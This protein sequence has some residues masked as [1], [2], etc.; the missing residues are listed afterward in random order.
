MRTIYS[1]FTILILASLVFVP[2]Y[3]DHNVATAADGDAPRLLKLDSITE[4]ESLDVT[5]KKD[6]KRIDK[7]IKEINK[8]LGDERWIDDYTLSMK[9]QKV[10]DHEKKAVKEISKVKSADVSGIIATLVESDRLLAQYEIDAIPTDSG[11]KKVDKQLAKANKEMTKAQKNI[12]KN[13]PDKAIDHFKKAWKLIALKGLDVIETD[14][15][16]VAM[17]PGGPI[18]YYVKSIH[19]GKDKKQVIV[20]YKIQDECVDLGP[21]DPDNVGGDTYEDAAMKFGVSTLDRVWLTEGPIVWNKWFKQNDENKKINL[22]SLPPV[23][24][25][26]FDDD[27]LGDDAIQGDESG[28]SFTHEPSVSEVADRPGWVGSVYFTAPPGDYILWTIHPAG[29]YGWCDGMQGQGILVTIP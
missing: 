12:E 5:K 26:P 6:Q 23:S 4:L 22:I 18:D 11:L 2:A 1:L 16:T 14:V 28:G 8:S 24:F 7:A 15:D 27:I 3:F 10:F 13:K 9:G 25:S 17:V 29:G 20:E 21:K 19:T